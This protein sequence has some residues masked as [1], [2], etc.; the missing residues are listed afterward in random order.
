MEMEA[1]LSYSPTAKI[2]V[3][4][5]GGGGNNAV[6]TMLESGV[7]GVTFVCAN[8]DAQALDNSKAEIKL[9]IGEK[10]T[11]GL[12]AGAK[13][14]IGRDAALES[15]TALKDV[16][17]SSDMIFVTAGMGGGTGTGAAPVVAQAAKEM[18]IL[19]VGV[20]TRPFNYEGPTRKKNAE[21]GIAELR[22]HVDSLIVIPNERLFTLS[23]KKAKL[24]EMLKM[25]DTVLCNAVSGISDLITRPGLI[26]VDFADVKTA[27][28]GTGGMA[29]MGIGV[30]SGEG[31]AMAA[32]KQ[33]INSA[34]LEDVSIAGA[35]A[36]LVNITA[37]ED[38]TMEEYGEALNY[39]TE[40]SKADG[41]ENQ[42]FAGLVFDEHAGDEI[43]ISVIAT[44]IDSKPE[45]NQVAPVAEPEVT[46][47]TRTQDPAPVQNVKTAEPRVASRQRQF[48]FIDPSS[49][50]LN[51]PAYFRRRDQQIAHAP[52][53]EDS[54]MFGSSDEVDYDLPSCFRTQ[55]N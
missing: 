48:T 39:I 42:V 51:K 44:G 36:L 34:L 19:T 38:I 21:A 23:P 26:N 27:M 9:Q 49:E 8:T 45:V 25:A 32:A 1:D 5:V 3:I 54:F 31:R 4:G 18:G 10:L 28:S 50:D 11:R 37:S 2:L 53:K 43:R 20:V 52:G 12:G 6:Q 17:K 22:E 33:A 24:K 14:E 13:P 47:R 16:M 15:I 35:R 29:M 55:A 7:K 40:C 30:A 41:I 46:P